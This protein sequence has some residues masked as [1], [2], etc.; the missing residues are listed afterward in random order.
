[1][2]VHAIEK[3]SGAD[4]YGFS[5]GMINIGSSS[6]SFQ[7][8]SVQGNSEMAEYGDRGE[9][10]RL[11]DE[12]PEHRSPKIMGEAIGG[13]GRRALENTAC[14]RSSLGHSGGGS[15]GIAKGSKDEG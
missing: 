10:I 6:D 12:A 2:L 14:V 7:N 3:C 1:M 9:G 4:V 13:M 5:D 15:P 11:G 8:P